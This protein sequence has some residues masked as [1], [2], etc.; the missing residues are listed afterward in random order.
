MVLFCKV[1]GQFKLISFGI[2]GASTL[3][4]LAVAWVSSWLI[5]TFIKLRSWFCFSASF[6][7][8]MGLISKSNKVLSGMLRHCFNFKIVEIVIKPISVFM[9][10]NFVFLKLS[11]NRL[12]YDKSVLK[13]LFIIHR[14]N[15]ISGII[16][17]AATIAGY[18]G[19]T[20]MWVCTFIC[21]ISTIASINNFK[22]SS[23]SLAYSHS[24]LI[25]DKIINSQPGCDISRYQVL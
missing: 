17:M 13:N 2:V 19:T 24:G 21:A 14:N 10:N 23:A 8:S 25:H 7:F 16:N 12:F 11:P 1:R 15:P 6:T 20:A 9:M 5:D 4:A 22:L 18:T 3:F